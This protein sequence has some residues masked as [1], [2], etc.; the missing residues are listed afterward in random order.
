MTRI[1][2]DAVISAMRR[3]IIQRVLITTAT[4]GFWNDGVVKS[5]TVE[6]TK[7]PLIERWEIWTATCTRI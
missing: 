6:F 5:G 3:L 4:L 1:P 2:R 7:F